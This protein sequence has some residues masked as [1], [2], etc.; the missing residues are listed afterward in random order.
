MM[1]Y[2]CIQVTQPNRNSGWLWA[3]INSSDSDGVHCCGRS[4]SS[5]NIS[6]LLLLLVIPA[7]FFSLRWLTFPQLLQVNITRWRLCK[8]S[9]RVLQN[10]L[11]RKLGKVR[12]NLPN[13]YSALCWRPVTHAQTWA[14]YSALYRFGRLSKVRNKIHE[15][16]QLTKHETVVCS[17]RSQNDQQNH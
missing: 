12:A 15:Q 11:K 9:I 8:P 1:S 16:Q 5:I 17:V 10:R 3:G 14:S 7:L 4:S 13:R 6:T 2:K